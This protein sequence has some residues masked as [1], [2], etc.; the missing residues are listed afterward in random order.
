MACYYTKKQIVEEI[1]DA[2]VEVCDEH[3]EFDPK[4]IYD[5][6]DSDAIRRRVDRVLRLRNLEGL[7]EDDHC[8]KWYEARVRT[9]LL[10]NSLPRET[11]PVLQM[12]NHVFSRMGREDLCVRQGLMLREFCLVFGVFESDVLRDRVCQPSHWA[13]LVETRD[14]GDIGI[15]SLA[16]YF[17]TLCEVSHR[18]RHERGDH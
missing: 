12:V 8:R 10:A 14:M 3:D 15:F 6:G 11:Q 2:Y 1:D 13:C 16:Q 4:L 7:D 5:R 18:R 9:Q 17:W